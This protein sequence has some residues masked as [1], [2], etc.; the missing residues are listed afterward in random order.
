M[1]NSSNRSASHK[2]S[3]TRRGSAGIGVA[4]GPAGEEPE[5]SEPGAVSGRRMVTYRSGVSLPCT[6]GFRNESGRRVWVQCWCRFAQLSDGEISHRLRSYS[7]RELPESDDAAAEHPASCDIET[8]GSVEHN[9]SD[10]SHAHPQI[11]RP[12]DQV[13]STSTD[14]PQVNPDSGAAA[15]SASAAAKVRAGN[16]KRSA[17]SSDLTKHTTDEGNEVTG[18]RS[19]RARRPNQL[20][21]SKGSYRLDDDSP[22]TGICFVDVD[23][24]FEVNALQNS[25]GDGLIGGH[26]CGVLNKLL[27]S[28][29]AVQQIRAMFTDKALKA[30]G[31]AKLGK[32]SN[33]GMD[34]INGLFGNRNVNQ[35][36]FVSLYGG[37]VLDCEESEQLAHEKIGSDR[38]AVAEVHVKK[39]NSP[40]QSYYCTI[41]GWESPD[42]SKAFSL[43]NGHI[44]NHSCIPNCEMILVKLSFEVSDSTIDIM[45]PGFQVCGDIVDGVKKGDEFTFDYGDEMCLKSPFFR[46]EYQDAIRKAQEIVHSGRRQS[47][48]KSIPTKIDSGEVDAFLQGGQGTLCGCPECDFAQAFVPSFDR[49]MLNL[50]PNEIDSGGIRELLNYFPVRDSGDDSAPVRA[51]SKARGAR[52]RRTK[53]QAVPAPRSIQD[54]PTDGGISTRGTVGSTTSEG[55]GQSSSH[56]THVNRGG[57]MRPSGYT[58]E[59]KNYAL[60]AFSD[61][62]KTYDRNVRDWRMERQAHDVMTKEQRKSQ[63]QAHETGMSVSWAGN[64]V[65]S[66]TVSQ[67]GGSASSTITSPTGNP[68]ASPVVNRPGSSAAAMLVSPS[69]NPFASPAVNQVGSRA[70]T[71]PPPWSP[72]QPSYVDM[73]LKRSPAGSSHDGVAAINA[74]LHP[75]PPIPRHSQD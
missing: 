39:P 14:I 49:S 41:I 5:R 45:L 4:G 36:E 62:G 70:A 23:T 27:N 58:R 67:T 56:Q 19:M 52:P 3:T 2:T 24:A 6:C 61:P 8:A 71:S 33:A 9:D 21:F 73:L 63:M 72:A 64:P 69:G 17:S 74:L 32:S 18:R 20:S 12:V 25:I 42:I 51:N 38:K 43:V 48:L 37:F 50:G 68:M 47:S 29:E 16:S 13:D 31:N 15:G 22:R 26:L 35:G 54:V 28:T 53:P 34:F 59:Y 30:G 75:P 40:I 7:S 44:M 11:S 10:G 46:D 66:P 57:C 55:Q 60:V 1:D 65:S